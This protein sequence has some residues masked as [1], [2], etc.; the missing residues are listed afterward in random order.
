L[1]PPQL[2]VE[3]LS[4]VR[5]RAKITGGAATA[6]ANIISTRRPNGLNWQPLLTPPVTVQV[7]GVGQPWDPSPFGVWELALADQPAVGE[8]LRDGAVQDL[9]LLLGYTADRPPWPE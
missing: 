2:S 7:D 3:Q 5:G 6:V 4:L 9:V 1:P 8:A